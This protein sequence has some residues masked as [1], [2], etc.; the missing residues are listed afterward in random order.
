MNERPPAGTD[1]VET[2]APATAHPRV[3][4]E[5]ADLLLEHASGALVA[6]SPD[7]VVLVWNRGAQRLFGKGFEQAVGR[8]FVEV[9]FLPE[10]RDPAARAVAEALAT[11]TS[12][13]RAL[14]RRDDGSRQLVEADLGSIRGA[15][16]EV[17]CLVV[18]ARDLSDEA[19][20]Q[21]AQATESKFR[22]LLEAAPD[23]IILLRPDKTISLVNRQVER[24]FGYEREELLGRPI[25]I[26]IPERF[27]EGHVAHRDRYFQEP[28]TRPMGAGV[29]L[30]GRRRDGTEF[31]VEISLAP[32]QSEQGMLVTAVIRDITDRKLEEAERRRAEE[33][34]RNL[35]KELEAF[36]YS[37][38]HDL[39]A[40][41]RAIDGFSQVLL[42]DCADKLDD[43][44]RSHLNRIRQASQR[45]AQLI[46][47]LL[48]LSRLNRAELAHAEVDLSAIGRAV[49]AELSERDRARRISWQIAPGLEVVGD[50]R[51]LH[52]ALA[53]LLENAWKFTR[54]QPEAAIVLGAQQ[55]GER[56][57]FVQDNGVGFDMAYASKLFSPFQRL[58]AQN[59]FEGTGIGLVTVQRIVHRHGGRIW[60]E[61]APGRG[62]TFFFT[63]GG[64]T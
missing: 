41:L 52:V 7:G 33:S 49:A 63:I 51:L 3:D 24:L 59:E 50:P 2:E 22:G 20:L 58:H 26:L 25:E 31:P 17:R 9:A 14:A 6:L 34:V 8:R 13:L 62:T 36:S 5:L 42:E 40:P 37:V 53:N 16:G 47:D 39:R 35:N 1:R 23:G 44:G 29:E 30:Y 60:V 38:S 18:A 15:R 19:R 55:N 56:V 12:K 21:Q 45:M 11:G 48:A 64:M 43:D 54:H 32:M 46:D 4:R 57:L 61:S 27:R 28:R 10:A